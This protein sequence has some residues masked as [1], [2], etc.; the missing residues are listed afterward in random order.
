MVEEPT[1]DATEELDR[2][3]TAP[4]PAYLHKDSGLFLAT[5][6]RVVAPTRGRRHL[7]DQ[8]AGVAQA[9]QLAW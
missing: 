2:V 7:P 8:V 4:V 6:L 5:R 3:G 9:R 1:A